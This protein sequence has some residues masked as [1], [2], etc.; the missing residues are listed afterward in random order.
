MPKRDKNHTGT[1]VMRIAPHRERTG[2]A[3]RAEV[4]STP[5]TLSYY[6]PKGTCYFYGYPAGKDDNFVNLVSPEMEELV[7]ARA[8][9][10]AGND[11]SIVS[12]AATSNATI[13]AGVRARLR[14][15]IQL[16]KNT[17][18]LPKTITA[19][20]QGRD[21]DAAVKVALRACIQPSTFVMAQPFTDPSLRPLYQIPPELTHYLNEKDHLTDFIAADLVPARLGDYRNGADFAKHVG[22]FPLPFVVK[23]SASSSG[24][25]VYLCNTESDRRSAVARLQNLTMPIIVEQLIDT[26]KNYAIHFGIPADRSKPV[27]ILGINEQLTTP[28]G[29]FVGGVVR[30]TDIPHELQQVVNRLQQ[31]ALPRV[32][33]MG[34]YGIG[35]I[36]VLIDRQGRA[37]CIDANFRMT[38]MSAFHCMITAGQLRAPLVSF[39]GSFTGDETSLERTLAEPLHEGTKLQLISLTRHGDTWRFNGALCYTTEHHLT[40]STAELLNRGITSEAL[41]YIAEAS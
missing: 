26:A 29:S 20:I 8:F 2:P 6:F 11:I 32:R 24:D 16:P 10:C 36:D 27:D 23:A 30:S 34:W 9:C 22:T 41:E 3:L 12:F 28:G 21:R 31:Q 40:S 35:G 38:G 1:F 7:A 18:V 14:L 4:I 37:Y 39:S 25:G 15:P 19:E 33:N 13:P 17:L 5:R